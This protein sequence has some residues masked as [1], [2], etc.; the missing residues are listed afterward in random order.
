MR[1]GR[2]RPR[3]RRGMIACWVLESRTRAR[4]RYAI[5]GATGGMRALQVMRRVSR[6]VRRALHV[7]MADERSKAA[8]VD[9]TST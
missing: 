5:A 7:T 1:V 2:T 4:M 6:C 9:R 3:I 8:A